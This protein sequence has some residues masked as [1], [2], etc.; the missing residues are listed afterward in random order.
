[1]VNKIVP[2]RNQNLCMQNY[3][4]DT[5]V[6]GQ[7]RLLLVRSPFGACHNVCQTTEQ[8][9]EI[10]TPTKAVTQSSLL[11]GVQWV[12]HI[13]QQV[14]YNHGREAVRHVSDMQVF[15][16]W[17]TKMRGAL[18]RRCWSQNGVDLSKQFFQEN[19]AGRLWK[20]KEWQISMRVNRGAVK[21][22]LLKHKWMSDWW[23]ETQYGKT[24]LEFWDACIWYERMC[25]LFKGSCCALSWQTNT[26]TM[27]IWFQKTLWER[28]NN[29]GHLWRSKLC[30][31]EV[32]KRHVTCNVIA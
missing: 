2:L 7:R 17:L 13:Y 5:V 15:A 26:S 29:S 31:R 21:K 11:V 25:T 20:K 14:H 19:L 24:T 8:I 22:N 28:E 4:W 10:S 27:V 23:G 3:V 12:Q 16:P 9:P 6:S 1:M 32:Q 30:Q 18:F